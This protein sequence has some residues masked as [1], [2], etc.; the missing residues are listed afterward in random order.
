MPLGYTTHPIPFEVDVGVVDAGKERAFQ[1]TVARDGELVRGDPIFA[2]AS[3]CVFVDADDGDDG[4][5]YALVPY[6]Q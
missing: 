3:S 4:S 1:L 2:C 5:G 6:Y